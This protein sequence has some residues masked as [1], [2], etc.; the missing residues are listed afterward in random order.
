MT[1]F[2]FL[3]EGRIGRERA[4]G[5]D[6]VPLHFDKGHFILQFD[7]SGHRGG[8]DRDDI[9]VKDHGFGDNIGGK[10]VHVDEFEEDG[11]AFCNMFLGQ[12]GTRRVVPSHLGALLWTSGARIL[13]QGGREKD[14]VWLGRCANIGYYPSHM[15]QKLIAEEILCDT[16]YLLVFVNLFYQ[17]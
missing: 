5:R 12:W 13:L 7:R 16:R 15:Q 3:R 8:T 4:I 17:F 11:I 2:H 14:A 10:E 9:G 6:K 1:V